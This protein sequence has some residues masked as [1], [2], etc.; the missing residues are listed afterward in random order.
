MSRLPSR[1]LQGPVTGDTGR[2]DN[3]EENGVMVEQP[4]EVVQ[5]LRDRIAALEAA[6]R[7]ILREVEGLPPTPAEQRLAKLLDE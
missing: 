4:L 1:P 5:D 3:I 2:L 7:D 6:G